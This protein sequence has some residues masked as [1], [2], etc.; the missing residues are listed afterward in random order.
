MSLYT[1]KKAPIKYQKIPAGQ[2]N[3]EPGEVVILERNDDFEVKRADF[4]QSQ[5]TLWDLVARSFHGFNDLM[6]RS[7]IAGFLVP[8]VLILIGI[9]IIYSEVWPDLEQRIKLASG[10]YNTNNV[11]LV[12]GDYIERNQYLS[13]PGSAYFAKLTEEATQASVLQP[14][15]VSNSFK[16]NFKLS[17]PSLQLNNLN[18]GANVESGVRDVYD[19]VL[20]NGL[21]HFSGTGLPIS[22]V[23]NNIVIYGHSSSGDYYERTHDPAGAFSRLNK[24]KIGDVV[25]IQL[26]GKS[27][28]YRVYKSKIVSPDDISILT[29]TYNKRTLTLF[30]CFPNGNSANRFVAIA[31]P[32]DA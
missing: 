14:D 31:K 30:T 27:Y 20:N 4:S 10:Y 11:A 9:Q 28:K 15:P 29:G 24:I 2:T 32:I 3:A 12:E 18:V 13:N 8:L 16:G 6:I 23:Q 26:N 21:A 25:D 17:I 22:D 7:R 19:K 1:Y 5:L